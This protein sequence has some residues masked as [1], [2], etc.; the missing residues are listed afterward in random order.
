MDSPPATLRELVELSEPNP[1]QPISQGTILTL[2]DT[3]PNLGEKFIDNEALSSLVR[4]AATFPGNQTT[5]VN[6]DFAPTGK[7]VSISDELDAHVYNRRLLI[8]LYDAD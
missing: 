1:H 2:G 7:H 8:Q 4:E 5:F 3:I 6:T